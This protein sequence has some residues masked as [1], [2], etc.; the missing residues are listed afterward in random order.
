MKLLIGVLEE[1]VSKLPSVPRGQEER[2]DDISTMLST[3][4]SV[5]PKTK[6]DAQNNYRLRLVF[7]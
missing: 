7:S 6:V 3:M 2:L 4:S 1:W 5:A